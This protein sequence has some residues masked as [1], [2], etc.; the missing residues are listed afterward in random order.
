M[1][2]QRADRPMLPLAQYIPATHFRTVESFELMPG[3]I[4]EVKAELE[5]KNAFMDR[6][7]FA[8]PWDGKLYGYVRPTPDFEA[9]CINNG[10]RFQQV[11]TFYFAD[12][13]TRFL[14]TIELSDEAGGG[15]HA[16][17]VSQEDMAALLEHCIRIESQQEPKQ[18]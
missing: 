12:W 2:N 10:F 5:L 17:T 11:R 6:L 8:M 15:E 3:G 9:F 13:D 7:S 16:Y 18:K 4:T 1:T 14:L